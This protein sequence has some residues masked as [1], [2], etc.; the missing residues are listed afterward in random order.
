MEFGSDLKIFTEVENCR[1]RGDKGDRGDSAQIGS[2]RE[3][4]TTLKQ[5]WIGPG[6]P[7]GLPVDRARSTAQSTG[8]H[9][10]HSNGPVDRDKRNGRPPGRPTESWLLS[11]GAGRAGRSTEDKG[12]S[13]D[14]QKRFVSF[15]D[16]D[17]FSVLESNPIRVS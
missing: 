11:V 15:P 13:T 10:V 5:A 9:G 6:R 8:V 17:S 1:E 3:R 12:R 14:R 16:S 2:Q 7:P 4:E